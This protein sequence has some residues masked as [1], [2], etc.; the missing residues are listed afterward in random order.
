MSA[1]SLR[2]LRSIRSV[3]SDH[4]L[5]ALLQATLVG[6]CAHIYIDSTYKI[7][8]IFAHNIGTYMHARS[9]CAERSAKIYATYKHT[10]AHIL[11][12]LCAIIVVIRHTRQHTY[13]R[14][15]RR[16]GT[17]VC[18]ELWNTMCR[19]TMA[20]TQTRNLGWLL[21]FL[22]L[23]SR[24]YMYSVVFFFMRYDVNCAGAPPKGIAWHGVEK[25]PLGCWSLL[26]LLFIPALWV[27]ILAEQTHSST[28]YR[29]ITHT[30]TKTRTHTETR[31][32]EGNTKK[33]TIW[34]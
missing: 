5:C 10:R 33:N 20:H 6:V 2:S 13:G 16:F 19:A 7:M 29:Y 30:H 3:E 9:T 24:V 21:L 17:K 34:Q 14:Q 1:C 12:T 18:S 25:Q 32:S 8:R 11:H 28:I 15:T 23:F 31:K 27:N 26:S 4:S 22:H